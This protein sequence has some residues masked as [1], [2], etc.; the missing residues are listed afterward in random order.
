MKTRNKRF[1]G[2]L[3]REVHDF[4]FRLSQVNSSSAMLER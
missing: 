1:V 2:V 4:Y 3:G